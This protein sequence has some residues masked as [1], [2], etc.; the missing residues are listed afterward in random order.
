MTKEKQDRL[1]LSFMHMVKP[2]GFFENLHMT[3]LPL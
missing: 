3:D 2:H 1:G